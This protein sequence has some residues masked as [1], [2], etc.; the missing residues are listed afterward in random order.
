M[1]AHATVTCHAVRDAL[2]AALTAT[3]AMAG[4]L[5][6][7]TAGRATTRALRR[8]LPGTTVALFLRREPHRLDLVDAAGPHARGLRSA[9]QAGI[10]VHGQR[11][12]AHALPP[13][14]GRTH[15]VVPLRSRRRLIGVLAVASTSGTER[16]RNIAQ[17]FAR[18]IAPPL[19]HLVVAAEVQAAARAAEET[20]DLA[21]TLR[22]ILAG[23]RR[24]VPADAAGILV[25]EGA[26]ARV[27]AVDGHP[28][29]ALNHILPYAGDPSLDGPLER[30]EPV[31]LDEPQWGNNADSAPGAARVRGYIAAPLRA[32]RE[33]VGVLCLDSWRPGAFDAEDLRLA[34]QFSAHVGTALAR[35]RTYSM[36]LSEATALREA[37]RLATHDPS[38][39]GDL[40]ADILDGLT[41]VVACDGASLLLRDGDTARVAAVYGHAPSILGHRFEIDGRPSFEIPL[42]AGRPLLHVDLSAEPDYQALPDALPLRG[43]LSVPLMVRGEALGMLSVDSRRRGA[44]GPD[45]LA[46]VELYAGYVAAALYNARLHEAVRAMAERDP[47]TGLYNHRAIHDHLDRALDQARAVRAPL[48]V[49]MLDLDG[50]KLYNDTHG[51][52][53]GD[54]AL[55]IVAA[56]LLDT[57]RPG[58]AVG[59]YGGDEFLVVVPGLGPA[60]AAALGRRLRDAVAAR[61]LHPVAGHALPLRVSVGV[62]AYPADGAD[63]DLLVAQADARLYESKGHGEVVA[64]GDARGDGVAGVADAFGVLDGLV[65]AVDRK[66]RYTRSHSEEV[67]RLALLLA[68]ELGF[69][70]D[71]LRSV[72]LAGLLHDVGKIG[73]PDRILKKP[74]RLTPEESEIMNGHPALGE[75]IVAGLPDLAEIRTGVRSHHE[76]WDGRG[77]PD[78]LAGAAIPLLGRLLAVP[79]CYSAMTTDRPYRAARSPV[80][81]LAEIQRGSGTQFDPTMAAAFP[82]ALRRAHR[83]EARTTGWVARTA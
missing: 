55:Q 57:C 25:R 13:L 76:R 83:G 15:L 26:F 56:A 23:I 4:S 75:A 69:S 53:A 74:G 50:F 2:A 18:R 64:Q 37:A 48:A 82:R 58:D 34:C 5:E 16:E 21:G 73:V 39:G 14:L 30:G 42:R 65:T 63:R 9:W 22:A 70:P 68:A 35:A 27:I 41:R 52:P 61:T 44:Y 1:E 33:I 17:T 54:T 77:Y 43:H 19:A 8:L 32:G 28:A 29:E 38:R 72:R 60:D 81:A 80:S 49:A 40:T 10:A 59:R 3:S 66:D 6:C 7:A 78:G 31:L 45:D 79:D 46:R 12:T 20:S 51:H 47:V 67:T 62:A 24:V 36:T 71:T 11:L